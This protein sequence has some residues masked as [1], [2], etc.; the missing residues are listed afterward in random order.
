MSLVELLRAGRRLGAPETVWW[1]TSQMQLSR[2][3][4]PRGPELVCGIQR[5][6]RPLRA[7]VRAVLLFRDA[8]RCRAGASRSR[9]VLASLRLQDAEP[10]PGAGRLHERE[11]L[12]DHD[13]R[14]A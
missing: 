11:E 12:P 1:R 9:A 4:W 7:L 13:R 14:A 2:P 10:L 8:H 3:Q 6:L 5:A